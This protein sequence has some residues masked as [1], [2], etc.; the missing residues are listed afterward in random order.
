[1]PEDKRRER[2]NRRITELFRVDFENRVL[3][4]D[5]RAVLMFGPNIAAVRNR[6]GKEAVKDMD[7]MIAA[8]AISHDR[9]PIASRDRHPFELL[10]LKV[11]AP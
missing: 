3:P 9:C 8:I 5:A 2:L 11:V 4:F 6:H 1:M 10:G 7:G